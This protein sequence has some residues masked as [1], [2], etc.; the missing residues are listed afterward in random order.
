MEQIETSRAA[1]GDPETGDSEGDSASPEDNSAGSES[2]S[3]EGGAEALPGDGVLGA[4]AAADAVFERLVAEGAA[5]LSAQAGGRPEGAIADVRARA[6]AAIAAVR[7]APP[8][9]LA[10]AGVAAGPPGVAGAADMRALSFAIG[11]PAARVLGG[12]LI[13]RCGLPEARRRRLARRLEARLAARAPDACCITVDFRDAAGAPAAAYLYLGGCGAD[14]DFGAELERLYARLGP[15]LEAQQA[16]RA[17]ILKHLSVLVLLGRTA[18]ADVFLTGA[19]LF[20]P[21][22]AAMPAGFDPLVLE[23]AYVNTTLYLRPPCEARV[24]IFVRFAGEDLSG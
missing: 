18:Y 22:V 10:Q 20:G 16:K 7:A 23:V 3:S 1:S 24:G 21:A 5:A 6:R 19:D 11:A 9:S 2:D 12:E 14:H 15:D 8:A 17:E 13:R 4:P